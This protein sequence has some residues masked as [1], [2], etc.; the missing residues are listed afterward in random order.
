[1][2]DLFSARLKWLDFKRSVRHTNAQ[3]R[4]ALDAQLS[5]SADFW[6]PLQWGDARITRLIH[7]GHKLSLDTCQHN[8]KGRAG[9]II[10]K[11]MV[12][13]AAFLCV[14]H[15]VPAIDQYFPELRRVLACLYGHDN[16]GESMDDLAR[17]I[18]K[19][20]RVGQQQLP[21]P[22]NVM[23]TGAEALLHGYACAAK[24]SDKRYHAE[25]ARPPAGDYI[26]LARAEGHPRLAERMEK[27]RNAFVALTYYVAEES[28]LP[29][30]RERV[31]ALVPAMEMAAAHSSAF[32]L[33]PEASARERAVMQLRWLQIMGL[34]RTQ[35]DT[36]RR[37]VYEYACPPP[38]PLLGHGGMAG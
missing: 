3:L 23:A 34:T 12:A 13:V 22:F 27:F 28:F 33:R 5:A 8:Y 24:Y 19:R 14:V 31:Q 10:Q 25:L 9:F 6:V 16:G 17:R 2:D 38:P 29:A 36:I 11:K 18:Y 15:A 30:I 32:A 37:W 20:E 1:M 7:E 26:A 35:C 21:A 4:R